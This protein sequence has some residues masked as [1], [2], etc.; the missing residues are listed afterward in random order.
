M[1]RMI[2]MGYW[3]RV[4]GGLRMIMF[5]SGRGWFREWVADVLR[6]RLSGTVISAVPDPAG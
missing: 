2:S 4:V 5:V 3:M 1:S 6:N